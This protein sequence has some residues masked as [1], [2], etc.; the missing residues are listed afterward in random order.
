MS[1]LLYALR[2]QIMK[3]NRHLKKIYTL[4]ETEYY[5]KNSLY[6]THTKNTAKK[7]I[8][9]LR[10]TVTK[11]SGHTSRCEEQITHRVFSNKE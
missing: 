2:D 11:A 7:L 5:K 8:R 3:E 9:T 4:K 10:V 6:S 1:W